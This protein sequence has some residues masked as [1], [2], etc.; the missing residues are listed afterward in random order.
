MKSVTLTLATVL[1]PVRILSEA[2]GSVIDLVAFPFNGE[3]SFAFRTCIRWWTRAL[4]STL[5]DERVSPS[6]ATTGLMS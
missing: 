6:T 1:T 5:V 3:H 4:P 2:R